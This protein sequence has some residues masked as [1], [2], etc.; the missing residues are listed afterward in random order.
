V[1]KKGMGEM[2]I[3]DLVP[4]KVGTWIAQKQGLNPPTHP[5]RGT[6]WCRIAKNYKYGVGEHGTRWGGM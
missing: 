6:V 2:I 3:R 5:K 1:L 4:S